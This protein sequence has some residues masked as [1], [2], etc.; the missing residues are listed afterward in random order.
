MI[1]KSDL[2]KILIDKRKTLDTKSLS[3]IICKNITELEIYKKAKNIYAYYPLPYEVDITKCF[4]DRT[5]NWFLPK[6]RGENLEF[7]KYS[8]G[9]KMKRGCFGVM[10]PDCTELSDIV[11]DLI[12]VPA[13]SADKNNYRLGYGKGYYDR[14]ISNYSTSVPVT[15]TP[16]FSEKKNEK[17]PIC[18][19]DKKIDYIITEN[20]Y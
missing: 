13:L 2:R 4:E 19:Y 9:D 5:K 12:I 15:L 8:F 10:E 14:F 18:H 17:L 6:V 1:N 20:N 16:I 3:D 11:P 7:Y